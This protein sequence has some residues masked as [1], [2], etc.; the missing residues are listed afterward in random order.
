MLSKPHRLPASDIPFV[1]K[2]GRRVVGKGITFIY[3]PGAGR[4]CFIVSTKVDKRATVRNRVRRLMSESVRHLLP[5]L[6]SPMDAIF[7]ASKRL[8]GLSQQEVEQRI[9]ETLHS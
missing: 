7:I 4:F 6:S 2:T 9:H 1:M 5:T 8:V 3:T